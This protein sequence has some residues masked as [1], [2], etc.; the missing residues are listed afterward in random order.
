MHRIISWVYKEHA[1]PLTVNGD[2]QFSPYNPLPRDRKSR[3]LITCTG[4]RDA[5][6]GIKTFTFSQPRTESGLPSSVKYTPGQ[7]ASFDIKV[8]RAACELADH[9]VKLK[10]SP[11]GKASQAKGQRL[12]KSPNSRLSCTREGRALLQS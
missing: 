10:C 9:T 5:A 1:L 6:E 3:R 4:I 11:P 12:M 2:I 7:Y 8:N